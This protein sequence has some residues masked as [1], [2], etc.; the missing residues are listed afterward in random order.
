LAYGVS[1]TSNRGVICVGGSNETA[2]SSDAFR[3]EWSQG[4]LVTHPLPSL[5]IAL[6][7]ASWALIGDVLYVACGSEEPGEQS[8][9]NRAFALDLASDDPAW[10][11]LSPL[12]GAP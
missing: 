5:P 6:S 8:A 3:L 2:H 9:T 10:R 12:P 1:A 11:E 7:G 4:K